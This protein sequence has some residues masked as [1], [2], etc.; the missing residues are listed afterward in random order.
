M[1]RP[2]HALPWPFR[3]GPD[4]RRAHSVFALALSAGGAAALFLW[5][6]A[7]ANAR[8]IRLGMFENRA[9]ALANLATLLALRRADRGDVLSADDGDHRL[10]RHTGRRHRR[11]PANLADGH[12]AV[13]PVRSLGRPHRAGADDGG[14]VG[15]GGAGLHPPGPHR[16]LGAILCRTACW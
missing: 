5:R 7:T 10:G 12:A 11:L 9:F 1:A 4:A 6:E 15:A 2:R 13:R 3:L 16:P 8:M 14:R